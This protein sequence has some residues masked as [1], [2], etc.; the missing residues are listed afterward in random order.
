MTSCKALILDIEMMIID[1]DSTIFT[2]T[3]LNNTKIHSMKLKLVVMD[4]FILSKL[5]TY[6]P[7]TWFSYPMVKINYYH[8]IKIGI[9]LICRIFQFVNRKI[10]ICFTI[11]IECFII[12]MAKVILNTFPLL[13]K[14]GKIDYTKRWPY[15]LCLTKKTLCLIWGKI[16]I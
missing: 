15:E 11:S 6:S 5:G 16:A 10:H 12:V 2:L 3:N 8:C 7:R 13:I 4:Q 1:N 9:F 14:H